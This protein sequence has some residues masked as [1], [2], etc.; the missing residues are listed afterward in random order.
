MAMK[1]F[2]D[3]KA[4]RLFKDLVNEKHSPFYGKDLKDVFIFSMALGFV[5]KKRKPL[6]KRR[7]VADIS[8]FTGRQ[9]LLIKS[10]AVSTEGNLEILMDGKKVFNIAEEYANEGIYLLHELI[11][12]SKEDPLKILDKKITSLVRK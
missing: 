5:L 4:H 8:V 2:V 11:F 7:D 9:L 6:R 1:F 3:E 10:I 12:E